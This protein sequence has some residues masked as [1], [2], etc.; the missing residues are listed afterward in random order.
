MKF[1]IVW[2][3]GTVTLLFSC[4]DAGEENS[5][6]IAKAFGTEL[7]LR[8]ARSRMPKGLTGNDSIAFLKSYAEQWVKEQVLLEAAER[9]LDAEELDMSKELEDYRKSLIIYSYENAL[10][11]QKLDTLVSESEMMNYYQTHQ[12]DFSLKDNIIKVNFVKLRKDAPGIS[13]AKTMMRSQKES[14]LVALE[15]YCRD[16]AV[17]FFL[18]TDSWL[19]FSDLLKEVPIQTYDQ[20]A[21]LKNNRLI[22]FIDGD[23]LYLVNIIGFRIKDSVSPFPFEKDNIRNLILNKRKISLVE[24]AKRQTL[25]NAIQK[26]DAQIM[27]K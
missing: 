20:E 24:E 6:T 11:N 2:L 15:N 13:R 3:L 8:E 5:V 21:F 16:N 9:N 12:Q 4:G 10:V 27:I 19:M 26:N 22:E 23:Y 14:D 25:E 7:T 1:S 18:E 17:N